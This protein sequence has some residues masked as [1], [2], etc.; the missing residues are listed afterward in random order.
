[1]K[2]FKFRLERVLEYR[3][4]VKRE[5]LR[6]LMLGHLKLRE[7]QDRLEGLE[8]A[9]LGNKLEEG[10]TFSEKEVYLNGLFATRM[11][12]QIIEQRDLLVKTEEELDR[13]RAVYIEASKEAEALLTLKKR[14]LEEYS[15]YVNKEDEKTLDELAVQKGNTFKKKG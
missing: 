15:Q 13:R 1:M 11:K 4:V 10:A 8:Q 6:E 5:R 3:E 12:E 14:K 2:K 9:Q 7:E